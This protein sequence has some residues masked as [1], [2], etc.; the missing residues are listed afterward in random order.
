M[1][2]KIKF[3]TIAIIIINMVCCTPDCKEGGTA[4]AE[5]LYKPDFK[6][7]F[8]YDEN[9][10]LRFLKNGKDTLTFYSQGYKTGYNYTFTQEDCSRKVPLEYK[11]IKFI[12]SISGTTIELQNFIKE[13]F[14]PRFTVTIDTKS[15]YDGGVGVFL[16]LTP[17]YLSIKIGNINYNTLIYKTYNSDY[18]YYKALQNGLIKFKTNNNTFELIP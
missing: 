2:H 3:L 10:N 13:N 6:A 7:L 5:E 1:K 4:P 15:F 18:L 14:T 9:Q 17:P 8:P 12:E 11:K 16:D